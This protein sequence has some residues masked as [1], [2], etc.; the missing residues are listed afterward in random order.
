MTITRYSS[1]RTHDDAVFDRLHALPPSKQGANI[2]RWVVAVPDSEAG[3][4]DA[5]HVAKRQRVLRSLPTTSQRLNGATRD[6]VVSPTRRSTRD[7]SPKKEAVPAEEVLVTTQRRGRQGRPKDANADA[8][9]SAAN[10]FS[11]DAPSFPAPASSLRSLNAEE[12]GISLPESVTQPWSRCEISVVVGPILH[13]LRRIKSFKKSP[14]P[15]SKIAVLDVTPTEISPIKLVP[16]SKDPALYRGLDK[17]IDYVVG[18]DLH[19][20][21]LKML[22]HTKYCTTTPSINQTAS[23]A[24]ETPIFLNIEVK[25]RH[26]AR[27]PTWDLGFPVFAIEIDGDN[28]IL[29][30]AAARV[31]PR[32][33]ASADSLRNG[34][35]D[36]PHMEAEEG[37]M[38]LSEDEYELFFFGPLD[39]GNTLTLESSKRLLA[40]LIDITKWGQSEFRG[41]WVTNVQR[42]LEKRL[43]S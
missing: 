9:R 38:P 22:R 39:L 8:Q 30:V 40:N 43:G 12:A 13:L 14:V 42:V 33:G 23:F 36:T 2:A 31:V 17:R 11:E 37:P 28:W 41:W 21:T 20:T 35:G 32:A 34:E 5:V 25:R 1:K 16:F 29:R 18:L 6:M 19:Q 27:D 24:N 15:D 4:G 26:V 10:A 3:H 7:R